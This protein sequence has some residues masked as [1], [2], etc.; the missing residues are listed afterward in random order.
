[1]EA[2]YVPEYVLSL[3]QLIISRRAIFSLCLRSRLLPQVLNLLYSVQE[4]SLSLARVFI[5]AS[6]LTKK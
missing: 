4:V 1:M 2:C 3:I 6:P 5:R